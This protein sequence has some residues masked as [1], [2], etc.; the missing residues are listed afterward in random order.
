MWDA[1]KLK[2][3]FLRRAHLWHQSANLPDRDITRRTYELY[4]KRGREYGHTWTGY[5]QNE[6]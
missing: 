1:R 2:H 5:K 4:E 6:N 3:A